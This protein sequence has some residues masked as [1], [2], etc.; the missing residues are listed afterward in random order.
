MIDSKTISFAQGS[1][2]W[3]K[4]RYSHLNASDAPAMMGVS[5]YRTRDELLYILKTGIHPEIDQHTQ[6]R[7]DLGHKYE[8][9]ARPIIERELGEDLFAS[10]VCADVEGLPLS[11]SLDGETT[12]GDLFEH[13]TLK[14]ELATVR[15]IDDLGME[16]KVQM[17]QQLMLANSYKCLFVASNGVEEGM[18]K[19]WYHSDKEL[20]K[21]IIAG[22]HQLMKDLE[23]YEV[24]EVIHEP[25]VKPIMALPTLSVMV[26]GEVTSSNLD[27][28]KAT[29]LDFIAK[30]NTDLQSDDDFAQAENTVKFCKKAESDL[31]SVQKQALAQTATI[32]ELFNTVDHLREEMRQKR[33]TLEKLVK[34][35]KTVVKQEIT[36]KGLAGFSEHVTALNNELNGVTLFAPVPNFAAAIKGKRTLDSIRN[37]VNS[38]LAAAKIEADA[39][40][41]AYRAN[42]AHLAE[43]NDYR[44]LFHDLQ[45]I[46]SKA[47]DD[48]AALVALRIAQHKEAEQKRLDAERERMRLEEERKAQAK[49]DEARRQQ[50][51]AAKAEQDA[52]DAADHAERAAQQAEIDRLNAE[53]QA[54]KQTEEQER[55]IAVDNAQRKAA[56]LADKERI[57][58]AIPEYQAI[59]SYLD[60]ISEIPVPTLQDEDATALLNG[61]LR[62]MAE[63]SAAVAEDLGVEQ[64]AQVLAARYMSRVR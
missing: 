22:W 53:K 23:S 46:I 7:F 58:K 27:L 34:S 47:P 51:A 1:D 17:Q 59:G 43:H 26:T 37:A 45:Q 5:S 20:E 2:E 60:A 14:A 40:A 55:Q 9:M 41:Q 63:V 38:E 57:K 12:I 24:P 13:K 11:A 35:Q 30:I 18:V 54:Q 62:A 42:L 61:L 50:E 25:E 10:T 3:L 6:A 52:K 64:S 36:E 21:K 15:T 29:A 28:Y 4:H 31:E 39:I 19:V 44:F 8:A 33:L 16:Y 56:M 32:D 49:V 48:F